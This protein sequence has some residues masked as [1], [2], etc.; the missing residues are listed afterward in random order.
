MNRKNLMK[1][2]IAPRNG[3]DMK[4]SRLNIHNILERI[5]ALNHA[6][7]LSRAD[8][9]AQNNITSALKRQK[10]SWQATLLR[11]YPEAAYLKR[12]NDNV[13]GEELLSVRL[14]TPIEL[15]GVI[16]RD[17]EHIPLRVA[18]ELFDEKELIELIKQ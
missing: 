18:E 17:A 2:G 5:I 14:N 9:G 15:N 8:F 6:W 10:S 1:N 7:K 12:D 13:D 3:V 4:P 11:F 16:R